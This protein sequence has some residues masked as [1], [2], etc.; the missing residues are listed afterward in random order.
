MMRL[1]HRQGVSGTADI[2]NILI[3]KAAQA[4]HCVWKVTE[5]LN[6]LEGVCFKKIFFVDFVIERF[7]TG[8]CWNIVI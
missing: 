7:W 4:Q 1:V 3:A 2:L 5:R 8:K 6:Y